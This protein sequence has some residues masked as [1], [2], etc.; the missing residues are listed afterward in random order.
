MAQAEQPPKP[1]PEA[2][3]FIAPDLMEMMEELSNHLSLMA[4]CLRMHQEGREGEAKFNASKIVNELYL[5]GSEVRGLSQD[6]A[7]WL[8]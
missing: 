4:Q 1:E 3:P 7:W 2:V 8:K 6:L 5:V